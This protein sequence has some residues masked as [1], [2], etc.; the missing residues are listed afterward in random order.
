MIAFDVPFGMLYD[1]CGPPT[2]PEEAMRACLA[3]VAPLYRVDVDAIFRELVVLRD[4]SQAIIRVTDVWQMFAPTIREQGTCETERSDWQAMNRAV[5]EAAERHAM[6]LAR[7]YD[8]FSGPD[9]ERDPVA[10]GDL[11][12][13]E[14]QLSTGGVKAFVEVFA[15]LGFEPLPWPVN[16][17]EHAAR[18]PI[19]QRARSPGRPGR[20]PARFSRVPIRCSPPERYRLAVTDSLPDAHP[21]NVRRPE[22]LRG[23]PATGSL[24]RPHGRARPRRTSRGP[25][26]ASGPDE[27]PPNVPRVGT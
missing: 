12:S 1:H 21:G 24:P 25:C 23:A 26:P 10:V 13:D 6:P 3:K 11:D 2:I 17:D 22:S 27:T 19:A 8:A 7:A 15:A 14:L 20:S 9:G 18:R 5:A 16:G 4:P